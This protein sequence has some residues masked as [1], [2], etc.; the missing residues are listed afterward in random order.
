MRRLALIAVAA[1]A[2][3]APSLAKADPMTFRE[4]ELGDCKKSCSTVLL[5]EGEI[6]MGTERAFRSAIRRAGSGTPV[7]LHSPGGNVAGSLLLG[8]AFRESGSTVG[9]APGGAC[10]SACAYALLGGVNRKVLTGA[11]FG[12]HE[13]ITI[14]RKPGKK[15]SANDKREDAETLALL[16]EYAKAMGVNPELISLA[17]KTKHGNIRVLSQKELRRMRVVT[18]GG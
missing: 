18:G 17:A 15:L 12:V 3:V 7:L 13:F 8:V 1:V 5:G 6:V 14:G 10:Y 16:R 2:F 11:Q 4:V 9:V